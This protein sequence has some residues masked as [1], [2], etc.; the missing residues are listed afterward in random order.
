MAS[1]P[2][3]LSSLGGVRG[4]GPYFIFRVAVDNRL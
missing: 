3:P 4:R 2:N 1:P